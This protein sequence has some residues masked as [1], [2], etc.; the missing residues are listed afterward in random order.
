M[1]H[2]DP[3]RSTATEQLVPSF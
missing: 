3:V 1:Q 2:T